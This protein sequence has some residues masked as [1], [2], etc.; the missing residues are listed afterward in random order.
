MIDH[1]NGA[2]TMFALWIT[3]TLLGTAGIGLPILRTIDKA[4]GLY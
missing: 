4:R 3:A 2:P 1:H